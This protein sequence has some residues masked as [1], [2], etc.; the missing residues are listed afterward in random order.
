MRVTAEQ[1]HQIISEV[2]LADV[3][4]IV[5]DIER[6]EGNYICDAIT[7]KKFL[8]CFSYIASNPI[9]H[10]H[11]GMFEPDF[12]RKLL[13]VARTKPSC[14]DVYLV[15]FAEFVQAFRR[16]AMPAPF[17]HLFLVEGGAVGVENAMKTAFDWKVRLNK[18]KNPGEERGSKILHFEQA[19]HGRCGYTLSV[20]NTADPKKTKFFPKFRWPRVVNPKQTFPLTVQNEAAT[21]E[22]EAEAEA[23]IR[24]AFQDNDGE[25]AAIL[26]ESI[27]GEGGDNHFR[28]EFHRKLR[29]LSD[30]YEALL[31]YDEIQTGAGLTG[32]FWAFEQFGMQ[33]DIICFGK[34]LQVCGIVAGPRID[35]V[36]NNV[37]VE[38]S[39]INSTWGGSLTDMVRATRYLEIMESERLLENAKSTGA[40]L[41]QHLGALQSEFPEFVMNVRGLGLMCAFDLK[42][43]E[44]RDAL[45]NEMFK[46]E[47]IVLKCGE[48][49]L[50]LRP[51]LTFK[52][53]DVREFMDRLRQSVAAV[54]AKL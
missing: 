21:K 43:A 25:I 6:S 22:R 34:K 23:Q 51:S 3:F 26:I 48:K 7:G 46:R 18:R 28:P 49:A 37:F 10:N 1:T 5:I 12:E 19:F 14:S 38:K 15:E 8:D 53:P 47:V 32:T 33:P 16:M 36:E 44:M 52:E 30:E 13:R 9:G 24:T 17:S 29:S 54:L 4:P 50:R 27:Q 2:M 42:T 45:V 20:T 40:I 39:R 35:G 41:Q 11:P 31:I